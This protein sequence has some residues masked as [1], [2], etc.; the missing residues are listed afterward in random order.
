[1]IGM[2]NEVNLP[3]Y[4]NFLFGGLVLLLATWIFGEQFLVPM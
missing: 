2:Q 4:S 3:M 1:M